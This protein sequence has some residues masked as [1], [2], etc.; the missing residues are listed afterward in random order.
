MFEASEIEA[1]AADI[2][3]TENTL[4]STE[5]SRQVG[6]NT[7]TESGE[8]RL[9]GRYGRV[10]GNIASSEGVLESLTV[11]TTCGTI[12]L[13]DEESL[14]H[15]V[16]KELL[17]VFLALK[18]RRVEL[19]HKRV[20]VFVDATASVAY[21]ANWGGPSKIMTRTV[22][23]TVSYTHLR[24]HETKANLVCRLLLEKKK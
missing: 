7:S 24:A 10:R 8:S 13:T 2:L 14:G 12:E 11:A 19:R 21:L 6:A 9:L 3:P 22:R 5:Q 15:H 20:C 17:G 4:H 23:K 18:S 1:A 16:H